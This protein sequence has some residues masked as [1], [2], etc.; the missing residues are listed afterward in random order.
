MIIKRRFDF[1]ATPL[2]WRFN[3]KE[4]NRVDIQCVCSSFYAVDVLWESSIHGILVCLR[5]FVCLCVLVCLC[6]LPSV[7]LKFWNIMGI[8][9]SWHACVCLCFV[10]LCVCDCS[11]VYAVD[12][13]EYYGNPLFRAY[14]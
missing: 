9:Y 1:S 8:F 2:K 10:R 7:K 13:L 3:F 6:L 4:L 14:L 12:I 11:Q 5:V